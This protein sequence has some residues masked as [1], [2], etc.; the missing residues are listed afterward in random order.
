MTRTPGGGS[1]AV[2]WRHAGMHLRRRE[3]VGELEEDVGELTRKG[4]E[5]SGK[6]GRTNDDDD[7][8]REATGLNELGTGS[9]RAHPNTAED[10]PH[11]SA[12]MREGSG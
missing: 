1:S 5:T 3:G 9:F 8:R 7:R 10:V 4:L 11:G 2:H 6:H 12:K